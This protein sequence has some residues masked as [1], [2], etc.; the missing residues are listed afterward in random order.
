MMIRNEFNQQLPSS[1]YDVLEGLK[2]SPAI[3]QGKNPEIF[4]TK[5]NIVCCIYNMTTATHNVYK[6]LSY[7]D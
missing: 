6:N 4:F 2:I 5:N 7:F 1:A 3:R